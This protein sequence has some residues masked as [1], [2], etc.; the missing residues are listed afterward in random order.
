MSRI[1]IT[2]ASRQFGVAT[3]TIRRRVRQGDLTPFSRQHG[4]KTRYYFDI[5]DL[6]RVFG[7]P[8]SEPK[9]PQTSDSSMH[10]AVADQNSQLR[11]EIQ[12]LEQEKMRF[13]MEKAVWQEKEARLQDQ[14]NGLQAQLAMSEKHLDDFRQLLAP[15]LESPKSFMARVRGVF[16]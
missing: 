3:N 7:E 14:I 1:S 9:Y 6:V 2:D 8:T 13:E 12:R 16:S 10:D 15:Q 4:R 11:S 5:S